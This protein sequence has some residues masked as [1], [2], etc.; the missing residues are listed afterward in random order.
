MKTKVI[1][2]ISLLALV[3]GA[4]A[5]FAECSINGTIT[6]SS[7]PDPDGPRYV[8]TL[9]ITWDTDTRF[10]LSHVNLLM[11]SETGT[12]SC[13]DFMDALSWDDPIGSSDGYPMGCTVD[14]RGYLECR[15]DH[16]IPGV[17]GILLKLEPVESPL[18]A[19]ETDGIEWDSDQDTCEPG[20]TG[21]GTFVFYSDLSPGIIDEEILSTVDKHGQEHC[22][23]HMSGDFP[24]MAC[25]PVDNED[26]SWGALKGLF[27]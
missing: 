11:D 21:T 17:G 24:A 19:Q 5:A 26:T 1:V 3:L 9:V 6:A 4:Q 22:F 20:P 8:Y 13:Q 14:Y 23:G 16:S 7:N 25:D 10:S 2:V 18:A 15:G 27:R 12:C